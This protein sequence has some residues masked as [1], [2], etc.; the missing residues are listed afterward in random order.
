MK[1]ND[2]AI[3]IITN[4]DAGL[5]KFRRELLEELIQQGKQVYLAVPE[6][7]FRKE[8][9]Q[10]GCHYIPIPL[11]R[12][13]VN[14]IHE[15]KLLAR[16][17]QI[18]RKVRP[19]AVLT[20]TIKPNIY[21]S[22]ACR[23]LKIPSA[24]NITGLGTAVENKGFLQFIT[25]FLYKMAFRQVSC[26]FFQNSHNMKFFQDHNIPVR[27][28][29]LLPGSGVNLD[30]FSCLEYPDRPMAEFLF[31]G[32]IM[33]EKGIDQF[34]DVAAYITKKYA[35][36]K[37]T[38]IGTYEDPHYEAV[39]K[40]FERQGIVCFEG[41][42]A[43][44]RPYLERCCCVIHPTYYPE[45]MSNVLLEAAAS[46]RPVITTARSGCREIVEDGVTGLFAEEQN[47]ARFIHQT[48]V[49]LGM[50][51]ADKRAMGLRARDK[52]EREFDRRIVINMYL[53]QVREMTSGSRI[54]ING[55]AKSKAA[56]HISRQ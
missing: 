21:G 9:E 43:D 52:M 39:I 30:D 41:A 25:V 40:E 36:T 10:L 33:K 51:T 15:L 37:F 28:A 56:L 18:I 1:K 11:S 17:I 50:A 54:G 4:S 45:G 35:D 49:F 44:V 3:L 47:S 14:P 12:H 27:K 29:V 53:E 24:A 22:M 26:V 48:E 13:G 5:Y 55:K 8:L 6:G 16:Y 32:R 34:L 19:G 23:L 46:G 42:R 2:N 31:E 38:I 20:Y 7:V